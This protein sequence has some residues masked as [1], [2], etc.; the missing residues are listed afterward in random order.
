MFVVT[1][2][3]RSSAV[4]KVGAAGTVTLTANGS[5]AMVVAPLP[6]KKLPPLCG[7]ADLT[8]IGSVVPRLTLGPVHV[9]AE[10]G[11]GFLP[12]VPSA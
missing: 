2:D 10:F 11:R 6:V 4:E 12:L 7:N 8:L 9:V 5:E 3:S 1:S